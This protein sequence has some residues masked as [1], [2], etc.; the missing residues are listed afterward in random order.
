MLGT[1]A[2]HSLP[3]IHKTFGVLVFVQAVHS[4]EEC[5]GR[6]WES[7][8]PAR[9]VAE[10]ISADPGRGFV[11]G[12]VLVVAFGVWCYFW[13]VR[14]NWSGARML[15]WGWAAIEAINGISH[16]LWAFREGGYT[17]GVATA[18]ALLALAIYLAIQLRQARA[19]D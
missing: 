5:W 8:P 6:L 17:P 15:A 11:M 7:Y 2:H 10:T 4:V 16:S 14:R 9:L 3:R 19:K 13:P 1:P 18:P 12:N